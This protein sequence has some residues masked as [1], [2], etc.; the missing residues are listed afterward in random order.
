MGS[1]TFCTDLNEFPMLLT[2]DAAEFLI[3]LATVFIVFL[4]LFAVFIATFLILVL[5]FITAVEFG[6][7]ILGDFGAADAALDIASTV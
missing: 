2:A 7:L 6:N 4:M 1:V 5:A 3:L